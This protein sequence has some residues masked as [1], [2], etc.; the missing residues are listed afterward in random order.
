M[1]KSFL[2]ELTPPVVW[3]AARS[4]LVSLKQKVPPLS[5]VF[6][7][8][9]DVPQ[10]NQW[11]SPQW[12]AQ[13]VNALNSATKVTEAYLPRVT[14]PYE[15]TALFLNQL[16]IERQI[17]VLDFGGASGFVYY[18]LKRSGALLYPD[19]IHWTVVDAPNLCKLGEEAK[20]SKDQISFFTE[21]PV[22]KTFDV[23]HISS[24]LQYIEDIYGLLES[25]LN[26]KPSHLI[27]TR[28]FGG[29][30]NPEFV[31]KNFAFGRSC[32]LRVFNIRKLQRFLEDRSYRVVYRS[33]NTF[34]AISPKAYSDVPPT[35]QVLNTSHLFLSL[36]RRDI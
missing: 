20:D 10:E 4:T 14:H 28:L 16:S 35:H 21:I 18:H 8:F 11:E 26:Q 12:H 22:G 23:L 31:T 5:G 36:D 29:T 3:Q 25:L 24:V 7:S 33:L 15:L 1:L 6:D 13:Q 19:N 2:R 30:D 9:S 27:L 34:E 32:P 17:S